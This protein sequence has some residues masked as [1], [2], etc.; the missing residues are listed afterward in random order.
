MGEIVDNT[1][2]EPTED[3]S[4]L[5][6]QLFMNSQKN[7]YAFI[8]AS[9]HNYND[10]D[11][12]LQDTAAVMWRKFDEFDKDT[13]FVAWGISISKNLIKK[14]YNERKRSRVQFN[15][16]LFQEIS[17][18]MEKSVGQMD[19]RQTALKICSQKLDDAGRALIDMRYGKGMTIKAIANHVNRSVQGMYKTIARLQD[20]LQ[21][22][23]KNE[24]LR[25]EA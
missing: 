8:L 2:G 22:C 14:Y 7:L 10:A 18:R 5:F 1:V 20:T 3:H 13:N 16:T 9:V 19:R 12:I 6:F 11:D 17:E 25:M 4:G 15:D 23:I 21:R 24:L